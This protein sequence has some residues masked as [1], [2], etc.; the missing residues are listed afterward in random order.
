MDPKKLFVDDRLKVICAYFGVVA[1][2]RDH[3]PMNWK[4]T[5]QPKRRCSA[6]SSAVQTVR[7]HQRYDH[8]QSQ[9][10]GMVERVW[11]RQD[12]HCCWIG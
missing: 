12:D 8:H 11:R 2:S 10:L 5:L 3:V 6:I 9:L 7:A 1:S 4:L